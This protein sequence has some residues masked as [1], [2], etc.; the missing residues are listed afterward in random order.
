MAAKVAVVTGASSG[1]GRQIARF[2]ADAGYT[3]FGTA[4][5]P[6]RVSPQPGVNMLALDV[7]SD[8]SVATFA[9]Q[10]LSQTGAVDLLVNNAGV[11]LEGAVEETS[12]NELRY[13]F[14]TNF[15][16]VIRVSKAFLP[17][18]RTR[19]SGR[20]VTIGSVAGFLPK[21]FEAAYSASK[22][23][24]EAWTESL[25]HEVRQFNVRSILIEPGFIRTSIEQ[26]SGSAA[27][28]L[29]AYREY[30]NHAASIMRADIVGGDNPDAVARIVL[31]AAS[32]PTP[33]LRYLAGKG[34]LWLR[35]QRTLL[36]AALFDLGLR[37]KFRL[38]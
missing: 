4:R 6:E 25:D 21:P 24:L 33:K 7:L 30:R 11:T 23:A 22:H 26:N 14:E 35:L 18:M 34:S 36:P 10:V 2:L 32:T 5:R 8:D 1:I 28:H 20:I 19:R 38:P 31:T 29:D 12:L 16:G 13:L 15:F 3:V 17:G 27:I 9:D 37:K